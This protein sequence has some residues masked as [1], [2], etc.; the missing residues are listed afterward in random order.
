MLCAVCSVYSDRERI[1]RIKGSLGE[2]EGKKINSLLANGQSAL[3]ANLATGEL[4]YI[5]GHGHRDSQA[6]KLTSLVYNAM[7]CEVGRCFFPINSTSKGT[8]V[9]AGNVL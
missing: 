2:K 4:F 6:H 7:R 5:H 8:S 9:S 1:A 3:D